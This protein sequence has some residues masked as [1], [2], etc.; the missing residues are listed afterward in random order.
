MTGQEIYGGFRT[1]EGWGL[2]T[3]RRLDG[4]KE[5]RKAREEEGG[6]LPCPARDIS[7]SFRAFGVLMS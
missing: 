3:G 7:L 2:G 5:G 4:Y 6:K 1:G